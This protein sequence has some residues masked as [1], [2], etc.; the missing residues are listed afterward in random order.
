MT[1]KKRGMG[2]HESSRMLNDEWLTPPEILG[3]LGNFDLDPCSPIIRPW[4]TA[5]RHYS[6]EDNG[7][8][9]PWVGRVWLNPPYGRETGVWLQRLA[10]HGNGIA[11]IFARTETAMFGRYGWDRA[12][13]MLFLA[14][15][16]HFHYV[17]GTRAAASGGA[18]SV[19]LAY[20]ERNLHSLR[21][22]I[23]DAME[24]NHG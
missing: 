6:I 4:D 19:L 14:G 1:T 11:L 22:A 10:D 9:Q 5:A 21:A 3:A 17:D 18:P 20:G 13:S 8:Q 23:D 16:L 24:G 7:L 15:R 12:D 2:S